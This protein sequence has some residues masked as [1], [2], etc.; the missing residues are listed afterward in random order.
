MLT[1]YKEKH[2]SFVRYASKMIGLEVNAEK[3]SHEQNA[4]HN[5]NI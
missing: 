3:M 4:G 1:Y 5:D 2:I